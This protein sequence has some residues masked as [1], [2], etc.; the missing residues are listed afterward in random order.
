MYDLIGLQHIFKTFE[1]EG[2]GKGV[3]RW[4]KPSAKG[5]TFFR[6]WFCLQLPQLP[7]LPALRAIG[8]GFCRGL[9][10]GCWGLRAAE[11]KSTDSFQ[12]VW[13]T[14]MCS[15]PPRPPPVV[16][17]SSC[18]GLQAIFIMA[19]FLMPEFGFGGW[20]KRDHAAFL[21]SHGCTGLFSSSLLYA[22][23][24]VKGWK[25]ASCQDREFYLLASKQLLSEVHRLKV[26]PL[27]RATLF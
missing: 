26:L 1:G 14:T 27:P 15:F 21:K 20:E 17:W 7:G 5:A 23:Q 22:E 10:S 8:W 11:I 16:S 3:N 12:K 4:V 24:S 18:A 13:K 19:L 2:G 6:L 9:F 25:R